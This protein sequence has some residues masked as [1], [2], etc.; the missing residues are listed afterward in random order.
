MR[1]TEKFW[2]C[3]FGEEYHKRNIDLE[4]NNYIMFSYIFQGFY[5]NDIGSLIEF[6]AGTGQNIK[7]LKRVFPKSYIDAIEVYDEAS[8][9]ITNTGCARNVYNI[10]VLDYEPTEK[11]DLVLTKGLLIHISPYDIRKVYENIYNSS[12][13]Y[14]LICEYYNPTILEVK[15]RG[16]SGK[17][18]KRDFY[19]DLKQMYPDIK[20][21][22]Y[23]FV[24][25]YDV[26]PQDDITW[27]LIEK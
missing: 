10:S 27:F 19:G 12:K 4:N 25:K 3:E 2:S 24:S 14:I 23:G 17:L 11:H 22:N 16:N 13:K 7:A 15:Y 20:L 6:G 5:D 8:Q 21:I 18:W 1:D 26:H 9:E